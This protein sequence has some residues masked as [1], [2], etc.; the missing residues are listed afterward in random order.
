MQ[1]I[2]HFAEEPWW[3]RDDDDAEEGDESGDEF[4]AGEGLAE[5]DGA[6]VGCYEGDEEAEDGCFGEG[7]VVDGVLDCMSMTFGMR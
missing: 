4:F 5:E 2:V 3:V 7:E 6:E 1:V